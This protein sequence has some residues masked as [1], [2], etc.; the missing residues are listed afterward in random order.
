MLHTCRFCGEVGHADDRGFTFC[1]ACKSWDATECFHCR[2]T[3]G[4]PAETPRILPEDAPKS[5][6]ADSID[7]VVK[8]S[9]IYCTLCFHNAYFVKQNGAVSSC[10]LCET[11]WDRLK[12]A[13]HAP[14]VK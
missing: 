7:T 8:K 6:I 14:G 10:R 2:T 9:R 11:T 1:R 4:F 3:L 13:V 12:A 5:V